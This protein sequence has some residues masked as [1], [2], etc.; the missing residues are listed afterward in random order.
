MLQSDLLL[1]EISSNLK[2]KCH[3]LI[4]YGSRARGD[5]NNESDYDLMA[6]HDGDKLTR[7]ARE[8]KSKYL[9]I[10]YYPTAKAQESTQQ[11]LQIKDGIVL[12]EKDQIGTKLLS[13]VKDKFAKGPS[14]L[15]DWDFELRVTWIK[16]NQSRI[17][18]Q[19]LEAHY[20]RHWLLVDVL[21]SYFSLRQK[22]YL[23]SKLSLNWLKENDTAVYRKFEKAL[24][25][26]ASLADIDELCKNVIP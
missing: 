16:K 11:L 26:E 14:A 12:F 3:T 19:D 23:G 4:L 24:H 7:E 13:D 2:I 15:E 10:W 6:L 1:A 5:F 21:E 8:Y 9:D 17:K 25:P 20:R 22:W 18:N